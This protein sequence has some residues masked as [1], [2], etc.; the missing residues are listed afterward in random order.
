MKKK[1]LLL[2][3]LM[4]SANAFSAAVVTCQI[5]FPGSPGSQTIVTVWNF[6]GDAQL[7]AD[8]CVYRL[9]GIATITITGGGDGGSGGGGPGG[10][11]IGPGGGH[12]E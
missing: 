1:L 8:N 10:N 11:P 12:N 4:F 7:A 2:L 6:I 9:D 5:G 3:S